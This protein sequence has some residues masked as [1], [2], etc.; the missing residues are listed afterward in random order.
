MK[1]KTEI[2]VP[3]DKA[4]K[5]VRTLYVENGTTSTKMQEII[6]RNV[7]RKGMLVTDESKFYTELDNA[8]HPSRDYRV[9]CVVA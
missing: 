8:A 4:S 7:V 6:F 5:T 1:D 2:V 9:Y 3:V